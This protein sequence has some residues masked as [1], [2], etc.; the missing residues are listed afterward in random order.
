MYTLNNALTLAFMGPTVSA[1]VLPS[2]AVADLRIMPMGASITRGVASSDENGYRLDLRNLLQADGNSVTYVGTVSFGNMSNNWN[3]GHPGYVIE[4]VDNVTLTDGCYDYLPNVILLNAGTNDCNI[5]GKDPETAPQRYSTLLAN[6]RQHAPDA[7]V[8]ASSLVPN[9]KDSTD[10]CIQKLNPGLY[11]AVQNASSAGQKT[12]WVDMYNVV[13]KS[14]IHTNDSTHP[15][16]AGY[17][18][19]A[20]AWYKEIKN[21]AANISAPDPNGKPVGETQPLVWATEPEE[22]DSS[23][24]MVQ[25]KAYALALTTWALAPLASAIPRPPFVDA[26]RQ[27]VTAGYGCLVAQKTTDG[28]TQY[29]IDVG[30]A[31]SPQ[32]CQNAFVQLAKVSPLID[33]NCRP[34]SAGLTWIEFSMFAWFDP[35][36]IMEAI[37]QVFPAM[38]W[39]QTHECN[40]IAALGPGYHEDHGVDFRGQSSVRGPAAQGAS[41]KKE[42]RPPVPNCT[43]FT[44]NETTNTSEVHKPYGFR[45]KQATLVRFKEILGQIHVWTGYI[46]KK[47]SSVV[48]S[49]APDEM[50]S[51]DLGTSSTPDPETHNDHV[52]GLKEIVGAS[53]QVLARAMKT[54][55]HAGQHERSVAMDMERIPVPSQDKEGRT[56]TRP[57]LH[58]RDLDTRHAKREKPASCNCKDITKADGS[59][60]TICKLQLGKAA[61][62]DVKCAKVK[63][64]LQEKGWTLGDC[65]TSTADGMML[66]VKRPKTNEQPTT[67][68]QDLQAVFP[69]WKADLKCTHI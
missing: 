43:D 61:S 26:P 44:L 60:H 9:L 32:S 57:R 62:H 46:W 13:P 35:V 3:E 14:E 6:I 38:R 22:L 51:H 40:S 31:R 53:E 65:E 41:I 29:H 21:V 5:P 8:I 68:V 59:S 49:L 25:A 15:T 54:E 23:P 36:A 7:V 37:D 12:G 66:T 47:V 33:W 11:E 10:E 1:A 16:D 17:Q 34:D 67:I 58:S 39:I 18:L 45:S 30:M 69:A 2:R 64:H 4:E 20:D 42:M 50:A 55:E 27:R 24:I 48:I 19:M 28:L 56:G 63:E 52:A